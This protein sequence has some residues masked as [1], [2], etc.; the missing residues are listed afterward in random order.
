MSTL[1][2]SMR[3]SSRSSRARRGG[4][5]S[6]VCAADLVLAQLG[7]LHDGDTG[8]GLSPDGVVVLLRVVG[9]P[10]TEMLRPGGRCATG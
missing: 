10:G 5:L 3:P 8:A 1:L 4:G 6:L 2:T 9:L 7:S